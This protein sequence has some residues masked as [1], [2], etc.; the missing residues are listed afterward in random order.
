[1]AVTPSVAA[2]PLASMTDALLDSGAKAQG[3]AADSPNARKACYTLQTMRSFLV[4]TRNKSLHCTTRTSQIIHCPELVITKGLHFSRMA[5]HLFTRDGPSPLR[6]LPK[7][8]VEPL[9]GDEL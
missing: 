8:M 4:S 2:P 3:I 7:D 6:L 9:A 1:M 5:A